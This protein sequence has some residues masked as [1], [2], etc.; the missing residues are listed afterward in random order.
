MCGDLNKYCAALSPSAGCVGDQLRNIHFMTIKQRGES[1]TKCGGARDLNLNPYRRGH[2]RAGTV[3]RP[4]HHNQQIQLRAFNGNVDS[5]KV[6]AFHAGQQHTNVNSSPS[7][8]SRLSSI[9]QPQ[10]LTWR[11]MVFTIPACH[12]QRSDNQIVL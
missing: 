9:L 3:G 11:V 5:I 10:L 8:A 2:C 4:F 12:A 6:I 1:L 7:I